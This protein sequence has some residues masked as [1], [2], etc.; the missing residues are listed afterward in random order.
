[1]LLKQFPPHSVK[2]FRN[3]GIETQQTL[4]GA[5]E[6]AVQDTGRRGASVAAVELSQCLGFDSSK[7]V[8]VYRWIE[9]QIVRGKGMLP[10][11]I[12]AGITNLRELL[13]KPLDYTITPIWRPNEM[14]IPQ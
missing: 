10:I 11:I 7:R 13:D 2:Q 14:F 8:P 1:M 12:A 9:F 6:G 3:S 4:F 5:I